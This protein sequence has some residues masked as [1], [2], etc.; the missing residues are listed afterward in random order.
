MDLELRP[1]GLE[2]VKIYFEKAADP[3]IAA[4]L[5]RGADTLEEA[6]E[7][8]RE[9]QKPGASSFGRVVMADG[10]YVGDV[11]CCGMEKGGD[12]EAMLSFCV[13]EKSLW[14]KGVATK[15]VGLF[16]EEVRERFG[17]KTVGAFCYQRNR[18]SQRVLEKN[19]FQLTETFVEDGVTSCYLVKSGR[20]F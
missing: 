19:G 8:Y 2:E 4:M 3:E 5:P 7:K 10:R 17:L 18:A 1:R 9:S 14:G 16:L 13:F 15:A 20:Q 11:W 12:P 6:V